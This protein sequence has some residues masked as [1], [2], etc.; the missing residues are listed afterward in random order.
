MATGAECDGPMK[1]DRLIWSSQSPSENKR[2]NPKRVTSQKYL[3]GDESI[4][5]TSLLETQANQPLRLY[6]QQLL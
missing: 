4:Q 3:L 5:Q 1:A 6:R 2:S